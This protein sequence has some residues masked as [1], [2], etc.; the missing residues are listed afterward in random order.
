MQA[1]TDGKAKQLGT[2]TLLDRPTESPLHHPLLPPHPPPSKP[3]STAS[4]P[5]SCSTNIKILA[6]LHVGHKL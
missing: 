6:W 1:K 2:S 4:H 5:K 3:H